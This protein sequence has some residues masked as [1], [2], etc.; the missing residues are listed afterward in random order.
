MYGKR[1][2]EN[3]TSELVVELASN[4]LDMPMP[5]PC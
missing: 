5:I 4:T 2:A 1:G 3:N